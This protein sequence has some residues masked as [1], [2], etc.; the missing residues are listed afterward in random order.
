MSAAPVVLVLA[1]GRGMRFYASGAGEHK[2][3]ALLAG[4][5][6]LSWVQ[7]AVRDAGLQSYLVQPAG[8]TAGMGESIALGVRATPDAG[9][10]LILP[11]DLP[12]VRP[13]SLLA[14]A[15][16]VRAQR[17]VVPRF[18]QQSGHPVAFGHTYY[19]K[20][21]ALKGDEGAKHVVAAARAL[22][23]V[24]DLPLDDPGMTEDIDTLSDVALAEQRLR[25]R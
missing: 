15:N 24:W 2:L 1:A 9:G 14:V 18:H 21:A 4:K 13:A 17:V 7:D 11:G 12:L 3:Q 19:D 10:W 16:A 8:G 22:G 25:E 20:L 5:P 6:V 23:R